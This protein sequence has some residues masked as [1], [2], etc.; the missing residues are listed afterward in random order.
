MNFIFQFFNHKETE[1]EASDTE[2]GFKEMAF[3]FLC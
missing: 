3:C 2:F 1:A